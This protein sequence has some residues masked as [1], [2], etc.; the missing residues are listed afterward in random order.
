[1][2]PL[3]LILDYFHYP[4]KETQHSLAVTLLNIHANVI[5]QYMIFGGGLVAK[6]DSCDLMGCSPPGSSVHGIFQARILKWI[7]ISFSRGSSQPRN[8]TQ[9]S[10][11]AGRFFIPSEPP[12]KPTITLG[13]QHMNLRPEGTQTFNCRNVHALKFI[14]MAYFFS[15]FVLEI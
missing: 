1:M 9:V 6:S 15:Y 11:I 12:G 2:R 3:L 10:C 13:F 5:I 14:Q 4:Q 7:A 8:R